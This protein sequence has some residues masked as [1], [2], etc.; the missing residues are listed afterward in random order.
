MDLRKIS[1]IADYFIIGSGSSSR[2]IKAVADGVE[3]AMGRSAQRL[4]HREGYGESEWVLLDYGDCIVHIF[5]SPA[6]Q[7]Y[8]LERLWGDAPKV[9]F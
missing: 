6:R 5:S 9:A 7:F 1:S 8:D 4:W 2:H 3:E